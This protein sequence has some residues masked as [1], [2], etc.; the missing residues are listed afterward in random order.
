MTK[1]T[2]RRGAL[3]AQIQR[4]KKKKKDYERKVIE[5][6]IRKIKDIITLIHKYRENGGKILDD[7]ET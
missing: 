7:K 6:N 3:E 1:D 4:T 2:A 5:E